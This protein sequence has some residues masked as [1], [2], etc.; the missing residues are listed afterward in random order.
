MKE[1]GSEYWQVD[2]I[3]NK[4][5][6]EFL[7]IGKD[8]QFLMSGSTAIDYVLHEIKDDLKIVYMPDYCC[9]S[10]VKPF[11]DNNY[12][13]KYY[14]T[15]IINNQY[16]I[17]LNEKCS[18]FFAMSYFGYECS[19]MDEYIQ[20]F[21]RKNIITIEDIT[22]RLFCKNNYCNNSDY[23]IA[24]LRKWF[25]IYTGGIAI[26]MNNAFSVDINNY[27]V[28]EKLI[29]IKKNAM[30][31]KR[32]YIEGTI[33][34]KDDFLEQYEIANNLIT[35]YKN[36]LMDEE[37]INI[38]KLLDIKK[39]INYR[40]YNA[41]IID[42]ILNKNKIHTIYHITDNDCP[43]FVPIILDNRD[44]IKNELIKN[45]IYCPVHWGNFM[46]SDNNIY[47]VELSLICDQRYSTN[48][49]ED[50]IGKLI[51]IVKEN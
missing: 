22:H 51:K 10:M 34:D 30:L 38:L 7:N 17:N 13:I 49:I 32:K 47:N 41:N 3:Q 19:N 43:I 48:N 1:I 45:K 21:K 11:L 14:N 37:S 20:E 33:T 8:K 36:K 18:I 9:E 35:N 12:E 15:D 50:Y 28:D 24:S 5:N 46:N 26:N 27:V 6:L 42:K 29:K 31:L 2:S 23:V 4:N 39:I 44:K 16:E 40:K 25:P